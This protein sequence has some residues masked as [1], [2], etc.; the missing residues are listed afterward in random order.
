MILMTVSINLCGG[1]LPAIVTVISSKDVIVAPPHLEVALHEAAG[2]HGVEV[3]RGGGQHGAVSTHTH[4][5]LHTLI[6]GIIVI[7]TKSLLLSSPEQ[8]EVA[9]AVVSPEPGEA[10]Q[11]L[12][13]ELLLCLLGPHT[14]PA[15]TQPL[16]L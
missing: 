9:E 15:E 3:G 11:Q 12:D 14:R 13:C 2:E 7:I 8:F 1:S 16:D 4:T 5:R 6:A 10:G